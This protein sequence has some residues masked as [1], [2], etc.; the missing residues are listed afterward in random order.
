[1]ATNIP[2][3]NLREAVAGVTKII[4]NRIE[5]DRDTEISELLPQSVEMAKILGFHAE[6]R[7]A[8]DEDTAAV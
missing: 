2:P 8:C 4:D 3:H 5:E 1:M 6:E 7:E